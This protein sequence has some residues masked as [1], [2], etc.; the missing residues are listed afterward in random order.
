MIGQMRIVFAV[1]KEFRGRRIER[2]AHVVAGLI[3]GPFDRL[4]QQLE[5]IVDRIESRRETALVPDER[6]LSHLVQRFTQ[7]CEDLRTAANRIRNIRRTVRH[8]HNFLELQRAFG[9]FA[10]VDH[11]HHRHRQRARRG[12]AEIAVQRHA[13]RHRRR[14]RDGDRYAEQ[15]V[16]AEIR[17]VRRTVEFDHRHVDFALRGRIEPFDRRPEN[18][19]YRGDRFEHALTAVALRIAV[20]L[21]HRLVRA[22]RRARGNHRFFDRAEARRDRNGHRRVAAR[23]EHFARAHA[24]DQ[25]AAAAAKR[26]QRHDVLVAHQH[27]CEGVFAREEFF[28][29]EPDRDLARRALGRIAAVHQV[30]ADR[31]RVVAADRSG[32]GFDRVGRADRRTAAFDRIVAFNDHRDD[33]RA[34]D[35]VDEPL[36]ER[37][38]VVFGVMLLRALRL[39]HEQLH[40]DDRVP[41]ALESGKNFP[42]ESAYDGVGFCKNECTF[43]SHS[44]GG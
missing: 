8:D 5:R 18:F 16:C 23:I 6:R 1:A 22:G 37:L 40:P 12:A 4:H 36:E 30:A 38:S 20:A 34:R 41:A 17:F 2:N 7:R 29:G 10:A 14:T 24:L 21:F 44:R 19:V 26:F 35:V 32:R 3:A 9:V 13:E 28:V 42:D 43:V 27:R 31:L 25:R 33:R 15:C 39:D 11:V